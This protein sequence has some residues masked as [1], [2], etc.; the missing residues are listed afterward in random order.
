MRPDQ[1]NLK[2]LSYS[3]NGRKLF[4]FISDKKIVCDLRDYVSSFVNDGAKDESVSPDGKWTAFIKNHNLFIRAKGAGDVIQLTKDGNEKN[5]YGLKMSWYHTVNETNPGET[6]ALK[7]NGFAWSPDSK[8][9]LIQR[10]DLSKAK[11]LNLFQSMP[12]KGYRANIWSYYR[13]LPGEKQ[14]IYTDY[15]I[16]HVANHQ[17]IPVDLPPLHNTVNWGFPSWFENSKGLFFSYFARGYKASFLVEIN[18]ENG[19]V[20][21]V[22]GDRSKTYVDTAKRYF[23]ISGDREWFIWNSERDGW[24]H[25]YLYHWSSGKLKNQITRGKFVVREIIGVDEKKKR[26]YFTAGGKDPRIDPYFRQFYSIGLNGNRIKRLTRENADHE[27]Y[28]SPDK[29]YFVDVYSRIDLPTV[30]ELKKTGNGET[31][32]KLEEADIQ[33]LLALGWQPPEP[34]RFKARDGKTDLYGVIFRPSDFD[35]RLKYPVLDSTYSGPHAVRTPK[36]FIK[37]CLNHDQAIAELGFIVVTIDGLGTANRSKA[38]HDF[39]YK[40][41][42]DNGSAD[43]MKG[44]RYLAEKYPYMDLDRVGIYGHSAGGYDAARA[45][46]KHVDFYKVAV[47]SA[48]NHDLR[49]AKAWWPEHYLGYPTGKFYAEQSNMKIAKNLKGKLLLMT[50]D[51]DN[52]VNPACTL[53]LAAEL[54]NANKDFDLIIIPNATHDSWNHPYFIRKMWDYFVV[55]LLNLSPPKDFSINF[56][57]K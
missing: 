33:D 44:I 19:K 46:F 8:K 52:N 14:G 57:K 9:I 3:A 1:L 23:K 10:V 12:R 24:N 21:L 13:A 5:S 32:L 22:T 40:N 20:R 18:G 27:I 6:K 2:K 56:R 48:G 26:L 47:S 37:G 11:V 31:V 49:M 15:S 51:M 25:S 4:F 16:I 54:V 36:T 45:M 55:H 7:N 53:R 29:K 39:S 43:H 17:M 41:L 50:G 35:P 34:F 28:L 42:G 38:F 30:A